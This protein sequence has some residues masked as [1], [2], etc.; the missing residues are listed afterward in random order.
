MNAKKL[1]QQQAHRQQ[2]HS[3]ASALASARLARQA[4]QQQSPPTQARSPP[5]SS[6]SVS[7][8]PPP[9]PIMIQQPNAA[10]AAASNRV[11]EPRRRIANSP[12]TGDLGDVLQDISHE[13]LEQFAKDSNQKLA[14]TFD[15]DDTVCTLGSDGR[16]HVI[17]EM[18]NFYRHI[19]E[20]HGD[21]VAMF[22]IT[23][24]PVG[25]GGENY[26]ITSQELVRMGFTDY[27][28]LFCFPEELYKC[29]ICPMFDRST[30]VGM[31]KE[32]IRSAL[33][34]SGFNI[35]F[36]FGDQDWD[37]CGTNHV[38]S[39]RILR[40]ESGQKARRI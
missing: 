38:C 8:P 37:H 30:E 2:Q 15:I 21:K 20:T 16:C 5:T 14:L 13:I 39:V 28:E 26:E 40:G 1:P 11:N 19:K 18:L 34:Y 24:R 27:A 17:P 25:P 9:P 35:L 36:N 4:Q 7:I 22:F 32:T 29:A 12:T 10:A 6:S 3:L 23:A 33:T 31:Y